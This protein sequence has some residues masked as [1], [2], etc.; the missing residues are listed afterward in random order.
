MVGCCSLLCIRAM[1]VDDYGN[2]TVY[3]DTGV[4][5]EFFFVFF[6]STRNETHKSKR[7][8]F[9]A[10]PAIYLSI[11]HLELILRNIHLVVFKK[12]NSYSVQYAFT[13]RSPAR[14]SAMIVE[15]DKNI[16]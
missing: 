4:R 3:I 12:Q 2:G 8:G 6:V 16:A 7:K 13:V 10:P 1:A 14:P 9:G 5:T 11:L 15:V